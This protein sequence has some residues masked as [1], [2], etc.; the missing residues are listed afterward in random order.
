M[1]LRGQTAVLSAI[2]VLVG[3]VFLVTA[4]T[5]KAVAIVRAIAKGVCGHEGQTHPCQFTLED[6]KLEAG[7]WTSEPTQSGTVV[8]WSTEGN[9]GSFPPN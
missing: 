3:M 1:D 9:P 5:E 8:T 2:L 6:K 4:T 7:R